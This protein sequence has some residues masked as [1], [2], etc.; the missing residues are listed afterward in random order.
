MRLKTLLMASSVLLIGCGVERPDTTISIINAGAFEMAGFNLKEDY[1]EDGS[2][3][4]GVKPRVR[5]ISSLVDVDKHACTDP[6]GLAN[7]K[8]YIKKVR[9]ELANCKSALGQP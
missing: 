6:V 8:A 3:K 9:E 4:P 5:Q 2:L 7:L 1:N